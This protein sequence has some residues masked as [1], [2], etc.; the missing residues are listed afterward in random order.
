[1]FGDWDWIDARS[2]AQQEALAAW[3]ERVSRLVVIEI[4]AGVDIPTIRRFS[5]RAGGTLVR[6]NPRAPE[7]PGRKGLSIPS[8]GLAALSEI[9]RHWKVLRR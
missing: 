4:G 5:E 7:I 6:I 1:M 2:A 8:G 3:L 9:H